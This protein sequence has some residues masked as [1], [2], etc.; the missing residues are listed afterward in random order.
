[1]KKNK[2]GSYYFSLPVFIHV[3]G[4]L[5]FVS[6]APNSSVLRFFEKDSTKSSIIV[7]CS[8]GKSVTFKIAGTAARSVFT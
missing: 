6:F 2:T 3:H 7:C 8:A 1:M 5:Y 4:L